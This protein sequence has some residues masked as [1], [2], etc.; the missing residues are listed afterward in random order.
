MLTTVAAFQK[1][2]ETQDYQ[3]VASLEMIHT[4]S[5]I[6]DDLPKNGR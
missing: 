3:V 6:H 5:L 2:M 4:Y 1:E